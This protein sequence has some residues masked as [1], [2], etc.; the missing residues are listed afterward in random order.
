MCWHAGIALTSI[1]ML[2]ALCSLQFVTC[3]TLLAN[4]V[5]TVCDNNEF[6]WL[7]YAPSVRLS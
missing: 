7:F 6:Y 3:T 2:F 5:I 4:I 1:A